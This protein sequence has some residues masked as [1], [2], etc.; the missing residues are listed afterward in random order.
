M[1]WTSTVPK[2]P[3]YYWV[4]LSYNHDT[5]FIVY[6]NKRCERAI[7]GGINW[8]LKQLARHYDRFAGP[9]PEPEE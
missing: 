3:G 1:K 6:I 4:G 7:G 2:T 9:I 8:S 5:K